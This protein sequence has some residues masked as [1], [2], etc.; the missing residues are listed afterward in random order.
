MGRPRKRQF[1]QASQDELGP[2]TQSFGPQRFLVDDFDIYDDVNT[3]EPYAVSDLPSFAPLP[4]D[5]IEYSQIPKTTMPLVFQFGMVGIPPINFDN[6]NLDSSS[7][8]SIDEMSLPSS[9][10]SNPSTSDSEKE[11]TSPQTT[12]SPCSCLAAMYLALSAL[13]NLPCDISTALPTVRGAA[14]TASE[15]LRCPHCG[16]TL[17]TKVSPGIET[18]QNMM[19]LGTILPTITNAYLRLLD[20]VD[21]ETNA[22]VA[23][24]ET[25]VFEFLHYGGLGTRDPCAE[26]TFGD[27]GWVANDTEMPPAQWRSSIRALL[28]VDIYGYEELG[29]SVRGLRGLVDD[30]EK[31]QKDRHEW[32]NAQL[33]D[34][35]LDVETYGQFDRG[36]RIC[37]NG[38]KSQTCIEI[39]KMAKFALDA[40]II[41]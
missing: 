10:T 38:E 24:G 6:L 9:S 22:A 15:A 23:A 30:A 40:L 20:L 25:K 2:S 18:F 28:K 39:F 1:L 19:L 13:Q 34:G 8:T 16:L 41:A 17:L 33:A 7:G 21:A 26:E 11:E 12:A 32:L 5:S 4:G 27:C 29:L 35:T 31:R 14:R 36:A 3:A 37:S